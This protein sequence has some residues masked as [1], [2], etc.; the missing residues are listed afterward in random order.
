MEAGKLVI[1]GAGGLS[2]ELVFWLE[3]VSGLDLKKSI[4][5]YLVDPQ[6]DRLGAAYDFPWLGGLDDYDP[7]AGDE[8][9]LAISNPQLK[10]HFVQRLLIR[11]AKFGTLVHPTALIAKT[12]MLGQGCIVGPYAV[13]S[14]DVQMEDFVTLLGL[15]SLGH[16]VKIGAYSSISAH[17][18]ITGGVAVGESV[19]FGSGSR[20]LPKLKIGARA[21]IGAGAVV[22]RSVT[23]DTTMYASPA[24]KLC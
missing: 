14:V 9:L 13:V 6:C 16:D 24:K 17:V 4:R 19:F 12:A 20:V 3:S 8:C 1:V 10:R 7:E 2:R 15:S 5:G 11:G 21:K 23:A 18:D 22:M